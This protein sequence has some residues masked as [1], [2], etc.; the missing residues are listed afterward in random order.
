MNYALCARSGVS[1]LA[2]TSC[3]SSQHGLCKALA[4]EDRICFQPGAAILTYRRGQSLFQEG[5]SDESAFIVLNGLVQQVRILDNGQRQIFGF[6]GAGRLLYEGGAHNTTAEAATLVKAVRFPAKL[7]TALLDDN[8]TIAALH[9]TLLQSD[10]EETKVQVSIMARKSAVG[11]VSAF[12]L[13]FADE[14]RHQRSLDRIELPMRREDIAD[15][16]GIATET[17][18]RSFSVLAGEGI[19][20]FEDIH[21]VHVRQRKALEAR[22]NGGE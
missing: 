17:V 9:R 11:K 8:R 15:Y 19:L 10:L 14:A 21:H 22:A 6:V 2:C 18:C 12:L 1:R 3:P 16:L 7:L 13:H 4:Q 5:R 20:E